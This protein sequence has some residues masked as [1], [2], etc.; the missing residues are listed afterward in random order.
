MSPNVAKPVVMY[1]RETTLVITAATVR[2]IVQFVQIA[3]KPARFLLN[4]AMTA[5][6]IAVTASEDK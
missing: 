4:P 6:F 3:V 2:C 1:A 5:L